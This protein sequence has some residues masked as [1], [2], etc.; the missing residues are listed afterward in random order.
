MDQPPPDGSL[1]FEAAKQGDTALIRQLLDRGSI[2]MINGTDQSHAD[3]APLHWAAHNGHHAVVC[4][5]LERNAAVNV[6]DAQNC[7]P[8][9][10]AC[11]QHQVAVCLEL[12]GSGG[13][14]QCRNVCRT[15]HV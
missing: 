13:D 11:Q 8:L 14:T 15:R 12:V 6:V 2:S 9:H 10:Y 7:T 4:L 3:W 5:L 1:I